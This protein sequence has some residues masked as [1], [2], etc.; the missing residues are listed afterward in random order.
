MYESLLCKRMYVHTV[1]YM[2]VFFLLQNS[3]DFVKFLVTC[4]VRVCAHNLSLAYFPLSAS[5]LL[6]QAQIEV[7][8]TLVQLSL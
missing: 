5:A 1:I 4:T 6:G 7:K 8:E 3:S 2:Y